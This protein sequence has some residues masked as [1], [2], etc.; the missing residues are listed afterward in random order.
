MFKL[1]LSLGFSVVVALVVIIAG[2][3]A[4]ARY[5]VI[6]MR[7]LISFTAAGG[8]VYAVTFLLERYGGS[9]FLGKNRGNPL[10]QE[11]IS[12][13]EIDEDVKKQA[14]TREVEDAIAEDA[15]RVPNGASE[16]KDG[17][18]GK[19]DDSSGVKFSPLTTDGLKH[20]IPPQ[21]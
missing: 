4:Q 8:L 20:V 13:A 18:G 3:V 11:W 6:F 14:E 15:D 21:N 1:E 5:S 17:T 9:F 10:Q 12:E 7:V 19:D 2:L 16:A